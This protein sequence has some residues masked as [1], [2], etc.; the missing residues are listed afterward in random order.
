MALRCRN[1]RLGGN[2]CRVKASAMCRSPCRTQCRPVLF[3]VGCVLVKIHTHERNAPSP[4]NAYA[5]H[6]SGTP[7]MTAR[8]A[9]PVAATVYR[10][11]AVENTHVAHVAVTDAAGRLLYSFGDPA[12]VTLARS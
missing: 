11:D 6:I 9:A 12:R 7:P 3:R 5:I 1:V 2:S 8:T 4:Y 10:G